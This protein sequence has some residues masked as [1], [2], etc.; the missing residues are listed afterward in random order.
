MPLALLS[1]YMSAMP[2]V[3]AEDNMRQSTVVSM[4]SGTLDK[5]ARREITR[6]WTKQLHGVLPKAEKL[7]LELRKTRLAMMG[8]KIG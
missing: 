3:L 4:G 1:S 7:P 8:I 5:S 2:A 6:E